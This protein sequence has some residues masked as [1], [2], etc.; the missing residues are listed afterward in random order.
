MRIG[1]P[2]NLAAPFSEWL[3]GTDRFATEGKLTW[4]S[5]LMR[6]SRWLSHRRIR[7]RPRRPEMLMS[8]SDP[9]IYWFEL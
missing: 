2:P 3:L 4:L 8:L 5:H 1:G 6:L 9:V 7:Y